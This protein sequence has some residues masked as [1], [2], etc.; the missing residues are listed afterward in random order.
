V[1]GTSGDNGK[2]TKVSTNSETS[3][4]SPVSPDEHAP[5]G[6]GQSPSAGDFDQWL[7][8]LAASVAVLNAVAESA[9]VAN[10]HSRSLLRVVR[11]MRS[12]VVGLLRAAS[13]SN[14]TADDEMLPR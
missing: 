10:V 4:T 7:Q 12:D 1:D 5:N 3:E 13:L 6:G 2:P 14:E 9:P 11:Q 8:K